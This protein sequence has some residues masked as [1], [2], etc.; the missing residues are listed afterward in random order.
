MWK[1]FFD[2][3]EKDR[4]IG[5]AWANNN[6]LYADTST[7]RQHSTTC[8]R[9]QLIRK[10]VEWSRSGCDLGSPPLSQCPVTV[11]LCT[12]CALHHLCSAQVLF[13]LRGDR[14]NRNRFT[15]KS[16]KLH[17]SGSS[18]CIVLEWR[19]DATMDRS[20]RWQWTVGTGGSRAHTL[21]PQ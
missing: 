13:I 19:A 18:V 17:H 14:E 12:L 7:S 15:A 9:Q 4:L 8:W 20:A 21:N 16:P 3:R 6:S 2:E 10:K 5:V 11:I 1:P